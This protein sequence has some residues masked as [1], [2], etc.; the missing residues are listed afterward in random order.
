MNPLFKLQYAPIA[1]KSAG[2]KQSSKQINLNDPNAALTTK[3]IGGWTG[4]FITV[5]GNE[6]QVNKHKYYTHPTN[7]KRILNISKTGYANQ[8]DKDL[9]NYYKKLSDSKVEYKIPGVPSIINLDPAYND[10]PKISPHEQPVHI[11]IGKQE[12][13]KLDI[14]KDKDSSQLVN[15]PIK[16]P[17]S[18]VEPEPVSS[19]TKVDTEDNLETNINKKE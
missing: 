18:T 7:V 3:K 6:K 8:E 2:T 19:D 1:S 4:Y 16:Q 12:E 15:E 17:E 9:V 10:P 14:Q 13:P 11:N 5:N